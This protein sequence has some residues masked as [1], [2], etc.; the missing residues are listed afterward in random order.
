MPTQSDPLP[1]HPSKY[2]QLVMLRLIVRSEDK[3]KPVSSAIYLY[4]KGNTNHA[5]LTETECISVS[6][7]AHICDYIY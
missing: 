1:M 6:S 2:K 4:S 5:E 7:V 3:L